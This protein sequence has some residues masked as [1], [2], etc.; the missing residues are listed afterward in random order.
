M[1]DVALSV[2]DNGYA[3]SKYDY[4]F[5]FSEQDDALI[6]QLEYNCDIYAKATVEKLLKHYEHLLLQLIENPKAAIKQID[7]LLPEDK[8]QLLGYFNVGI[9][10]PSDGKTLVDLFEQQVEL[11]PEAT[12][13]LFEEEKWT[14]AELNSYSN[15][16]AHF[17][18][19]EKNIKVNDLVGILVKRSEY[20][21]AAILGIMKAGAAYVPIEINN[22]IKRIQYI[23]KDTQV[24]CLIVEDPDQFPIPFCDIV[25]STDMEKLANFPNTNLPQTVGENDLAYVIYTSGSTGQP[26]GVG[27]SHKGVVNRQSWMWDYYQMDTN[28]VF[29]LKASYTFDVSVSEIF[30]PLS[31]GAK[32]VL[33]PEEAIFDASLLVETIAK[34]GVTTLHFVPSMLQAFL[35]GIIPKEEGLNSLKRVL[36]GGEELRRETVRLYHEL[37]D[38][39]LY[40]LYGPTEASIDI[41]HTKVEVQDESISIGKPIANAKCYVLD[42]YQQL[43]PQGAWGEIAISGIPLAEGYLNQPQLTHERFIT[44][45]LAGQPEKVYL[46]GDLGKW[47]PEGK[48][49]CG[50]RK[51]KQIKLRGQ[52]IELAE[53][54]EC[55]LCYRGIEEVVVRLKKDHYQEDCLVAYWVGVQ[56]INEILL[57][58]YLLEHLPSQMIPSYFLYLEKLPLSNSG[59]LD[60]KRL[61]EV[62]ETTT[63]TDQTDYVAPST[64][65]ESI[66]VGFM[67]NTL[68]RKP[69]GV[70]DNFFKIGGNSLKAARFFQRVNTEMPGAMQMSDMFVYSNIE[71]LAK[72][73]TALE[74][75]ENS[76]KDEI[77]NF[78]KIT[79]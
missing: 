36:S 12:A 52:R 75:L 57:K 70:R 3:V 47:L 5:R 4:S 77:K 59:K 49:I 14:Y 67:E 39:P 40:N 27:V 43:V 15:Q 22:P 35:Q 6:L 66:L 38:V 26:K 56:D 51:D 74:N 58:T 48:L 46:T 54:E 60:D 31:F 44:L 13:I 37:I 76:E 10:Y 24:K 62:N 79:I 69:I 30:L 72:H 41:C 25:S 78:K 53:I 17:L 7:Y 18:K 55:L 21:I 32:F 28:D 42:E 61:P 9:Q 63:V 2:Y 29:L 20:L 33:C 68:G 8:T 23:A 34:F 64:E 65:I 1:K 45:D 71:S 11:H 50:G 19:D 73:I 16:L